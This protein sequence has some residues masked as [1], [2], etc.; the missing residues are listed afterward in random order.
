MGSWAGLLVRCTNEES[1]NAFRARYPTALRVESSSF[2]VSR[3][4]G[5]KRVH[6]VEVDA[7]SADL[8]AEVILLV[9]TS[10]TESIQYTRSV[11]GL[12][13]R[14]LQCGMWREQG[15]WEAVEGTPEPWE[16]EAFYGSVD[17]EEMLEFVEEAQYDECRAMAAAGRLVMGL[18]FPRIDVCHA[19]DVIAGH[20][21]LPQFETQWGALDERSLP[22]AAIR[23]I[24]SLRA[25]SRKP[26]WKFW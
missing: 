9:Y 20:Y 8:D 5:T 14:H 13:A 11:R 22:P 21:Q 24:R 3:I 6:P 2:A 15:V 16:R 10:V 19:A 23:E 26:W 17:L 1:F 12:S 25:G 18:D 7:L 4:D